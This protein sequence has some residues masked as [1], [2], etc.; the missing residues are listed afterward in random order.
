MNMKKVLII[1]IILLLSAQMV[2]AYTG[3]PCCKS[4]V[5]ECDGSNEECH[6]L[7]NPIDPDCDV[8]DSNNLKGDWGICGPKGTVILCPA[9]K[10]PS[11]SILVNNIVK[12]IFYI[13][14]IVAPIMILI[15]AFMLMTSS[16]DPTKTAK[17]RAVIIWTCVG[18]AIILF[19]RGIIAIIRYI[20][21]G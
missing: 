5:A 12:W 2:F 6:C 8:S 7:P 4:G 21:G 20:L 19:A 9:S 17:A 16:G 13:A 18:L 1:S 11:F 3:Q 14:I 15:A 10:I